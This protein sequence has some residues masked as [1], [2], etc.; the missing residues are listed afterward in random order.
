MKVVV[1][2]DGAVHRGTDD[3]HT[4]ITTY[5]DDVTNVR[6]SDYYWQ[7]SYC[8]SDWWGCW[9]CGWTPQWYSWT[10]QHRNYWRNGY[11][12]RTTVWH[13]NL[14]RNGA[15]VDHGH[16]T[17][18]HT[19]QNFQIWGAHSTGDCSDEAQQ[20]ARGVCTAEATRTSSA[21]TCSC[22]SPQSG[23]HFPAVDHQMNYVKESDDSCIIAAGDVTVSIEIPDGLVAVSEDGSPPTFAPGAEEVLT[24]SL[25]ATYGVD[26]DLITIVLEPIYGTAADDTRRRLT[27]TDCDGPGEGCV[28]IGFSMNVQVVGANTAALQSIQ[29]QSASG[30]FA[31]T[32][33]ENLSDPVV[34]AAAAANDPNVSVEALQTLTSEVSVDDFAVG[35]VLAVNDDPSAT[36]FP[37]K[38]PTPSP[39]NSPTPSPTPIPTPAPTPIPTPAPTP[40][41]TPSPTA[42][43]TG[44]C[45]V[46]CVIEA[47]NKA[48]FERRIHLTPDQKE[49]HAGRIAKVTHNVYDVNTE[50]SYKQHR[51][52]RSGDNCVC[53]C[54]DDSSFFAEGAQAGHMPRDNAAFYMPNQGVFEGIS[55]ADDQLYDI[56]NPQV[57]SEA[58]EDDEHDMVQ[59]WSSRTK[60]DADTKNTVF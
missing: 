47:P 50:N 51:C 34:L 13:K 26:A 40:V 17:Q 1:N 57:E 45:P 59:F 44:S 21:Y 32:V 28:I 54:I 25:A 60:A 52:Y 2:N 39:T 19:L 56:F 3:D 41:P 4:A 55:S 38:F 12:R 9:H 37:T 29:D 48:T 22:I 10:Q 24:Q 11:S 58:T 27:E 14:D 31:S 6:H 49:T 30:S 23:E 16:T 7:K 8:C 46:T 42:A 35:D 36:P 15:S 53:E 20:V 43:P 18:T 33:V 5:D